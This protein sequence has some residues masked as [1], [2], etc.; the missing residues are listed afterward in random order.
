[1]STAIVAPAEPK[2]EL[3]IRDRLRDP[4]MIAEIGKAMPK[5]C[6]PDRMARVAMTALTRTPKLAECTQA[7]FFKCLLELSQWGLEPDGR[8]A[9]LIPF[10]NRKLGVVECT[11]ILDWKGLAELV[12]RSGIVTKLHADVVHEG[13]LFD[14]SMGE[15]VKHV[16]W[17]IRRDAEKPE[18]QGEVFAAYAQASL[19]GGLAKAEVLSQYAVEAIR[20]RSRAGQSGPWVTDW[21]EMAKKTAFRRLSKW[22]PL[23]A[24]IRDAMDRDDDRFEPIQVVK[25]Q[26]QA[27]TDIT[28]GLIAKQN[29]DYIRTNDESQ[30][31][32]SE[33]SDGRVAGVG[34]DAMSLAPS[35][36]Q[37]ST[38]AATTQAS[39]VDRG[40]VE[41]DLAEAERAS[42]P[43]SEIDNTI[44][45]WKQGA[46]DEDAAWLDQIGEE[47]KAKIRSKRG[48]G[49]KA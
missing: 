48:A 8:R 20:K 25:Q 39:T 45:Q 32:T 30:E 13:D 29:G 6:S 5:H 28:A 9:H 17:F 22:L 35:Q 49:S 46:S 34:G 4:A 19:T 31:D 2:R 18:K 11:L 16:P 47:R 37:D 12:Y 43:I 44:A 1:M 21:N 41:Y 23:S 26:P 24:D 7:S 38:P 14:Y 10:E 42:R 40:A 33:S 36:S 27:L 3:T 15:V